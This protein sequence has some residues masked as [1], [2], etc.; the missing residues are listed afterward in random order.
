MLSATAFV[1]ALISAPAP[2]LV[3]KSIFL[4]LDCSSTNAFSLPVVEVRPLLISRMEDFK[5]VWKFSTVSLDSAALANAPPIVIRDLNVLV[6]LGTV[7]MLISES[8]DVVWMLS[9]LVSAAVPIF[10]V[11]LSVLP[12]TLIVCVPVASLNALTVVASLAKF[13]VVTVASRRLNVV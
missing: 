1:N 2:F 12:P 10:R 11:W 5:I 4:A 13:S 8:S 7:P 9:L 6:V 3:N